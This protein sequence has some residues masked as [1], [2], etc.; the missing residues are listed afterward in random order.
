LQSEEPGEQKTTR[1]NRF[2]PD[3]SDLVLLLPLILAD[4]FNP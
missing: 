4:P 3:T 2:T 1:C